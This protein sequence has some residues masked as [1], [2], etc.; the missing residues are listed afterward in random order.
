EKGG[1]THRVVVKSAR[2]ES[3]ESLRDGGAIPAT[4]Q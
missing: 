3:P 4:N 1:T 2:K